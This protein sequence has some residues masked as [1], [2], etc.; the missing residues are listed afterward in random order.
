MLRHPAAP[1]FVAEA[2]TCLPW[3]RPPSFSV[4]L[5]GAELASARFRRGFCSAS[6]QAG[7]F[8]FCQGPHAPAP[9]LAGETVFRVEIFLSSQIS[10]FKSAIA[11]QRRAIKRTHH[12]SPAGAA[13]FSPGR[14][15]WVRIDNSSEPQRGDTIR[16]YCTSPF[17]TPLSKPDSNR[18][19]HSIY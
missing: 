8:L 13:H 18:Y 15:P 10:N 9:P 12:P 5:V 3:R 6:L 17:A 1:A 14:K 16:P 7:I 2:G 19:P 4:A 11:S